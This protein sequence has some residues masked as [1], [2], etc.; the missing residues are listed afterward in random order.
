VRALVTGGR[1]FAASWLARALL[2]SGAEV[3]SLDR[4]LGSP[5]G[6][7]LEGIAGDVNDLV[8]DLRDHD[9][10]LRLL[11]DDGID[12]VFHLAAQAI[13]GD[14]NASPVA[15]FETNIEGTWAVLEACREAGVERVVVASSDKAYGPHDNL[16][17][18]EES[19]LQPVF[20]Y[21][22]SKAAGDLI[23]R[24]YWHT[25]GL[26]VAVTRFANLYGGGDRN[27]SRLIPETVTAVLDGRPP[28]IRSDGSPQ[29]DFIHVE[30]AAAAYLA[31]ADALTGGRARGEAFNAGWGEPHSVR[32][33]VSLICE[34]GPTEVEPDYR[35]SGNPS[36]EIDRQFLD[37]TK[38]REQ[39][40]WEPRIDLREGIERTIDWYAAH[41]E[42][43]PVVAGAG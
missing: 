1:G 11:R 4:E 3:T 39:V 26:P 14:A 31:V 7:E 13:V 40:G 41:P 8:G 32:E 35:G 21:D 29:R 24:S 37:S 6:L 15:T 43:R 38:I 5:T 30:D 25:Y 28:V 17:Y 33:V 20:P 19:A 36:G 9:A 22:V 23:A 42:I 2:E 12:S 16:P 34:L 18:T 10:V 27:F